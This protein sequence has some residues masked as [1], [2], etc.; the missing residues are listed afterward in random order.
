MAKRKLRNTRPQAQIGLALAAGAG[1]ALIGAIGQYFGAKDEATAIEQAAK[2]QA[3]ALAEQ[4][5]VATEN[6]QKMIDFQK[7][8]FDKQRQIITNAQLNGQMQAGT[9]NRIAREQASR[10][11]LKRGGRKGKHSASF[12]QG[13]NGNL[14]FIVTD[15]GNVIPLYTTPEGY[16][17]YQIV[18]D[19]HN[20]KHKTSNGY[21][22]GVGIKIPGKQ[23]VEGEGGEILIDTPNEL[24]FNS[25][26]TNKGFNPTE[27]VLEGMHPV[28]AFNIQ[29]MKKNNTSPVRKL[30]YGGRHKAAWGDNIYDPSYMASLMNDVDNPFLKYGSVTTHPEYFVNTGG[31]SNPN[32]Y[33]DYNTKGAL[34]TGIG[35]IAGSVISGIGNDIASRRMSRAYRSAGNTLA[36]AYRSLKTID[37]SV[38]SSQMYAPAHAMAAL[39]API[40]NSGAERASAERSLQRNL[41]RIRRGSLSS[42]AGQNR[43][44]AAELEYNDRIG[45]IASTDEKLRQ[46]IIGENM[47]RITDIANE[48]ANRDVQGR[49][50][51]ANAYLQLLQYNNDI[52]NERITGAAQ[53]EADAL[54]QAQSVISNARATNFGSL[55]NSVATSLSGYGNALATN[56]K[57]RNELEMSRYGWTA[58]NN[59][60]YT[61]NTHDL[62]TARLLYNRYKNNPSYSSWVEQLINEFGENNLNS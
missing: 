5:R 34:Y 4:N 60:N 1:S 57:M 47:K 7:S 54:T 55:G 27:A 52:E 56:A 17:V 37:P 14:P 62:E 3:D 10:F 58:E 36:N 15:G 33:F 28:D 43:S 21:K 40:V 12:L 18:G 22:T 19:T 29:E 20:E 26:H 61:I 11:Q 44:A 45:Q 39:Q 8:E 49:R 53:A 50:D 48:N 2:M 6:Q 32:N 46:G 35:N 9:V 24:L 41:G 16:D 38:I 31:N 13:R 51:Y 25:K 42:A 23:T 59:L 30:R